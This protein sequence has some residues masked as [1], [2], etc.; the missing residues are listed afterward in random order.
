M[1]SR[2]LFVTG[3]DRGSLKTNV[4]IQRADGVELTVS[5]GTHPYTDRF[6]E[7]LSGRS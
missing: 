5:A 1:G 2:R 6:I 4:K 7:M 3:V